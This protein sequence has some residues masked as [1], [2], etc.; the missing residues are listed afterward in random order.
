MKLLIAGGGGEL[1]HNCFLVQGETVCFL[2]DCGKMAD[3]PKDP[4]PRLTPEQIGRLD[5]VFLTHSHADHTGALPWLYENGFCGEV[6]AA[7]ETLRQLPFVPHTCRALEALCLRGAG[8]PGDLTV[9]R[10][11]RGQRVVPLRRGR[12]SR[13]LFRRLHGGHA[14][15]CLRPHPGAECRSCCSGLR[16]RLGRHGE[17]ARRAAQ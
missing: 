12:Q 1:G 16:L 2:V 14:G 5:A 15:V 9:Q 4:Y 11:L 7:A 17:A 3:T 13:I 10:A 8:A 6:F